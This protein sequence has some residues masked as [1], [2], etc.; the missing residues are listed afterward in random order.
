M[1]RPQVRAWP[2]EPGLLSEGPLWHE[3]RQ[4]LLW[5]DILG[6]G[7]HR[8]TLTSEG[9]PDQV[10]TMVLDRHVGAVAPVAGGGYVLAAGQG[11]L[12]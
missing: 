6:R 11:F 1:T 3:E 2:L 12:F 10:S 7:F 8:A 9:S 5:V 4:E